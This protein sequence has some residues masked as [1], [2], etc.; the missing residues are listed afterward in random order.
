[1]NCIDLSDGDSRLRMGLAAWRSAQS[2]ASSS[3]SSASVTR[4]APHVIIASSIILAMAAADT[5]SPASISM[6]STASLVLSIGTSAG[7]LRAT[8]MKVRSSSSHALAP[9]TR[10]RA[11]PSTAC[12]SVLNS[13]TRLLVAPGTDASDSSTPVKIASVPS[14]PMSRSSNSPLLA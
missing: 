5:A 7:P 4:V 13:A 14:L 12:S 1:M 3:E 2:R 8:S 11:A 10:A 6:S 9:P